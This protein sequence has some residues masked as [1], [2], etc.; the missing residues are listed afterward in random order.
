MIHTLLV[1]A[2]VSCCAEVAYT[3]FGYALLIWAASR[4]RVERAAPRTPTDLPPV[5]LLIAAHNEQACIERRLRNALESDY[6]PERLTIVIGSDGSDDAT[7]AIVLRVAAEPRSGPVVRLAEFAK[8]RG[9]ASVLN[10]YVAGAIAGGAELIVLSD[11]NTF[12]HPAAIRRLVRVV[13]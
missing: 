12:H 2:F 6:P 11:A 7:A 13:R 4:T 5:T 9:K 1:I 10:D 8:R 3:Y